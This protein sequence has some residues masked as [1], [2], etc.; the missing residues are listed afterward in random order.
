MNK[1]FDL[2]VNKPISFKKEHLGKINNYAVGIKY[3]GERALIVITEDDPPQAVFS[4]KIIKLSGIPRMKK[5]IIDCEFFEGKYNC[6]DLLFY[7]DEDIRNEP[8]QK[9]YSKLKKVVGEIN[10]G[11]I[12]LKETLFKWDKKSLYKFYKSN[13][14]ENDGLIFTPPGNYREKVLKWKPVH[15]LTIDVN[16]ING[17]MYSAANKKFIQEHNLNIT[18][19]NLDIS[20]IGMGFNYHLIDKEPRNGIYEVYYTGDGFKIKRSRPDKIHPNSIYVMQEILEIIKNPVL[21]SDIFEIKGGQELG[22]SQEIEIRFGKFVD[23]KFKNGLSKEQYQKLIDTLDFG[24]QEIK[25]YYVKQDGNK[26]IRA[27]LDENYKAV[28]YDVKKKQKFI[29]H[30][31]KGIRVA[32]AMETLTESLSSDY[33][34]KSYTFYRVKIYNIFNWNNW[35]F[36]LCKTFTLQNPV[37]IEILKSKEPDNYELEVELKGK[38][39][40]I[41]EDINTI[42]RMVTEIIGGSFYTGKLK[43]KKKLK[44]MAKYHNYIKNELI[45]KYALGKVLDIGSGVGGDISKWN[46]NSKITEVIGIEPSSQSV[47]IAH[48]RLGFTKPRIPIKFIVGNGSIP[49]SQQGLNLGTFDTVIS[50]FAFHYFYNQSGIENVINSLKKGGKFIITIF[51]SDNVKEKTIIDNGNKLFEL[52]KVGK[53]KISVFF[54]EFRGLDKAPVETLINSKDFIKLMENVGLKLVQKKSFS[55]YQ[56]PKYHLSEN[57][58]EI[59]FMYASYVFEKK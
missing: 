34:N 37:D 49:F 17:K 7:L 40:D 6:F 44:N 35:E 30:H 13:E 46:D 19:N 10:N 25:I 3:D 5:T 11:N 14:K 29:D 24:K 38:S 26:K 48:E 56:N 55:E 43:K 2:L 18:G 27:I 28:G 50:Q 31:D 1:I 15:E 45:Q 16:I 59:S 53:D 51:D 22:T 23:G 20:N 47:R 58:K 39:S 8:Y 33:S 57:E 41:N 32:Y 54:E 9:R 21:E 12:I 52:K 4:R 42:H 36:E